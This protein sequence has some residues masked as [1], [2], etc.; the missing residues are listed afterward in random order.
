MAAWKTEI[1]VLKKLQN[2]SDEEGIPFF[3][4]DK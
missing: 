1:N 2:K 3:V 4:F